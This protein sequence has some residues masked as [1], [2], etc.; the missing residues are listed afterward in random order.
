MRLVDLT[1]VIVVVGD[2]FAA[3]VL[4]AFVGEVAIKIWSLD[5]SHKAVFPNLG[6]LS[7]DVLLVSGLGD[8]HNL[9][10]CRFSAAPTHK[11]EKVFHKFLHVIFKKFRDTYRLWCWLPCFL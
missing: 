2:T 8:H 6:V 11:L 4:R 10:I 9:L 7:P 3:V 1:L 5:T